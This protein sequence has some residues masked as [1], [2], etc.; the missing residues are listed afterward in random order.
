[1]LAYPHPVL[2][3]ITDDIDGD[4]RFQDEFINDVLYEKGICK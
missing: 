4:T 1:M 3:A 2:K